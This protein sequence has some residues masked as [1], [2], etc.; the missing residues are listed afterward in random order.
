MKYIKELDSVR[1]IAVFFVIVCHWLAP[2]T[3]FTVHRLGMLGAIGVDVFFVLS[4]FLI[5]G[6]LLEGKN[7]SVKKEVPL[8]KVFINFYMRRAL[9]IFPIF[10][11]VVI[12][13]FI[14][15]SYGTEVTL[16]E[17]TYSATYTINF[18]FHKTR[19]WS[20][21]TTHF[22]SLAVEE[23]FYLLWPMT[24]L[25]FKKEWLPYIM[26]GFMGI[27]ILTQLMDN[28]EFGYLL[29]YACF[30]AFA[31]GAIFSWML[32]F[33][34]DL[35]PGFFKIIRVVAILPFVLIAIEFYQGYLF[36]L[37]QRTLHAAVAL[38]VIMTILI[39]KDPGKKHPVK[40]LLGN[41]VLIF[42]GRIS[43]GIYLYHLFIPYIT[44]FLYKTITGESILNN[45]LASPNLWF[46]LVNILFLVLLSWISWI[47][48][49]KPLLDL[50]KHF[51]YHKIKT[52]VPA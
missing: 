13:L 3:L 22:W 39:Y 30:D 27:G 25:L 12:L 24:I 46:F 7:K 9:R 35:V 20:G 2:N 40:R 42:I 32:N 44:N 49:E 50:K 43:Y 10:Y 29:T 6:I 51:T 47:L 26:A 11:L 15:R 36:H 8:K 1:A 34:R 19:E 52:I 5:T 17:L 45:R 23:Q 28:N 33:R 38:W 14:A 4:G 37:P 16:R 41:K 48:I 18:L 31:A 21:Y